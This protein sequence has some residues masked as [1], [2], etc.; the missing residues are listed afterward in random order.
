MNELVGSIFVEKYRPD[1]FEDIV[2]DKKKLILKYMSDPKAMPSFIFHSNRPGTGKTSL[3]KL[4]IKTLEC[5][6]LVLN[7]SEERGID[8]IREKV[9]LFARALSSD[10]G[11]KRCVFMDEAD[12]VTKIGLDSLRNLMEEYSAN[13]FFILSCNNLSKI[14]EPIQSRCVVINFEQPDKELIKKRLMFIIKNEKLDI[15][16]KLLD[17]V[18]N[19]YYPDIRSMIS[20]I[21]TYSLGEAD[22]E[23]VAEFR[24]LVKAIVS[25]D[26]D[27]VYKKT[28]S[29]TLRI[30]EFVKWF[31]D[32]LF[33]NWAKLGMD[34]TREIA[35]HLADIEKSMYIGCNSE[36]A[37]L[38][39]ILQIMRIF[40]AN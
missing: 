18:T 32:Y 4:M 13:C 29:G 39:N 16:D 8:T 12:G 35:V 36:I 24:V 10:V 7:A 25:N 21:Q 3:A 30:V 17:Q 20:W 26:V 38:S 15:A 5:D 22:V 28:Y 6:S 33:K 27:F 11:K 9:K 40:K 1:N 2:L 23:S 14:I 31:F 37:F 19:A 34:S